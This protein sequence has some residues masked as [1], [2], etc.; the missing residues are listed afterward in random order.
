MWWT[1]LLIAVCLIVSVSLVVLI[2]Y[3]SYKKK[4]L[5]NDAQLVRK[6]LPGVDCGMCG[7]TNCDNFA[8]CVANA[9]KEP[10]QC[11]LIKT[12]NI[13]KIKEFFK[14]TYNQSS[15]LVAF[16]RCK[17]GNRAV[18]RYKYVGAKSCAIQERLHSGCKACKFAC[19]GCGDCVKVCKYGA[20]KINSR[21][22]AEIIRSKCTG[23]GECVA[24][25][26]NNLISMNKMKVTVGIVCNNKSSD[27]A[28][29]KKCEVGCNHCGNCVST[30]PVGAISIV[31]NVPVID[32]DKCIECYKC[33]AVCP[34]HVISRL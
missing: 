1:I 23:C 33:V 28:I 15:K 5:S 26:P 32:P 12:E 29:N 17:G 24:S 3:I 8:E 31:D 27:P 10:E 6:M 4:G 16:V 22:C 20:I 18:D 21:G 30:C 11:K 14:P 34:N 9:K 13:E 2:S 25:C 19:L 7:E